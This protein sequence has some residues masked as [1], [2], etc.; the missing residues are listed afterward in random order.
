MKEER[1]YTKIFKILIKK[2][3]GKGTPEKLSV[4]DVRGALDLPKKGKTGEISNLRIRMEIEVLNDG[5][6]ILEVRK[7]W[8][9]NR[10]E[11]GTNY[12]D[13]VDKF[14]AKNEK[15]L[16][17]KIGDLLPGLIKIQKC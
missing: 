10:K 14:S 15:E 9:E 8:E 2:N 11:G 4:K 13:S 1:R 6:L 3:M 17:K 12:R 16:L 5:A 7:N